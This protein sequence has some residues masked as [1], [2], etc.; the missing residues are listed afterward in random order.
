MRK[1]SLEALIFAFLGVVAAEAIYGLAKYQYKNAAKKEDE[2]LSHED[3]KVVTSKTNVVPQQKSKLNERQKRILESLELPTEYDQLTAHQKNVIA[4]IEGMLTYAEGK[5]GRQLVFDSFT[6][7]ESAVKVRAYAA[8]VGDSDNTFEIVKV[9]NSEKQVYMDGYH[10]T[11][12][13]MDDYYTASSEYICSKL[14][15]QYIMEKIDGVDFML[16]VDLKEYNGTFIPTKIEEFS[17]IATVNTKVLI[18]SDKLTKA[19]FNKFNSEY[20][21]WLTDIKLKGSHS[22]A[23]IRD[24]ENVADLDYTNLTENDYVKFRNEISV[25]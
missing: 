18:I 3:I 7:D 21:Q 1:S 11:T 6:E 20:T 4:T 13:Y 5:Y 16:L 25:G 15:K 9:N 10:V 17:G 23:L 24:K 2:E 12:V 19:Q 22:V 14:L 8:E